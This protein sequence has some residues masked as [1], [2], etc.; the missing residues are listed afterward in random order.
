MNKK[1]QTGPIGAIILYMLFVVNWFIWLGSFVADI[2]QSTIADNG[3]V[4]IEAFFFANLNVFLWV[5]MTLSMMVFM[6]WSN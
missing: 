5:I 1:A 2:G 3:L 6:V 4:G